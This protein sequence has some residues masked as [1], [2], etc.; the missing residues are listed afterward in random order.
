MAKIYKYTPFLEV[1]SN[2][3]T[4][5]KINLPYIHNEN[6][7]ENFYSSTLAGIEDFYT[8]GNEIYSILFDG[9]ELPLQSDKITVEE[10]TLT[11]ELIA[12][13]LKSSYIE[14][15]NSQVRNKIAEKYSIYDELK[16]IRTAPS[17]AFDE[18]NS[19]AEECR[20]WGREEKSKLGF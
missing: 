17:T 9:Y 8:I 19:Y 20:A 1:G 11:T 14:N 16:L 13:L 12:E 6:S 10:I 3:T 18:Y 4:T 5:H 2:Y 15:I 7:E